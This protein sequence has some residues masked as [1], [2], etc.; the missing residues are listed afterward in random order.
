MVFS[1]RPL[2]PIEPRAA[3]ATTR[4]TAGDGSLVQI[5]SNL[6]SLDTPFDESNCGLK[7]GAIERQPVDESKEQGTKMRGDV[8]IATKMG[9]ESSKD[10]DGNIRDAVVTVVDV[11]EEV[12]DET[13]ALVE[14]TGDVDLWW[15]EFLFAFASLLELL[16]SSLTVVVVMLLAWVGG[17]EEATKLASLELVHLTCEVSS[18]TDTDDD[19]GDDDEG[20]LTNGNIILEDV[21]LLVSI[22][23][24]LLVVVIGEADV[25]LVVLVDSLDTSE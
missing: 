21:L 16:D 23:D 7:E 10:A 5:A 17:E 25:T 2:E 24:V 22:V 14:F 11:E 3:F 9:C 8:L 4:G 12:E 13:G 19:D 15:S 20:A 1:I 18:I 6:A